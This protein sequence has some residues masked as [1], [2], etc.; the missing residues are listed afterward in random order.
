MAGQ[1]LHHLTVSPR[2]TRSEACHVAELVWRGIDG[3]VLSDETATGPHGP[4]AVRWLRRLAEA[5]RDEP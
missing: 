5:A 4:E 1:V 3:F 2:P